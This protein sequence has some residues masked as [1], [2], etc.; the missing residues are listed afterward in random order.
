MDII[1]KMSVF[2][3]S[4]RLLKTSRMTSKL[5]NINSALWTYFWKWVCLKKLTCAYIWL[6]VYNC[7]KACNVDEGFP[8]PHWVTPLSQWAWIH[9][10][11][12]LLVVCFRVKLRDIKWDREVSILSVIT[13]GLCVLLL[14]SFSLRCSVNL[15][16]LLIGFHSLLLSEQKSCPRNLV[17]GRMPLLFWWNP[18]PVSAC[19]V[20][21]M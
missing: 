17:L 5:W 3:T 4:C 2:F 16:L 12:G 14:G 13:P 18:A 10:S 20:F 8:V 7:S 19:A 9:H 15:Y 21:G 11:Q 1:P 6:I